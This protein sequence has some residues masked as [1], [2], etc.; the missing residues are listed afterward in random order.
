MFRSTIKPTWEDPINKD[1]GEFSTMVKGP[2]KAKLKEIWLKLVLQVIGNQ[3][4]YGKN[5]R[6]LYILCGVDYRNKSY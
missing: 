1:G 3:Y 4:K 5:V 2:D 6:K